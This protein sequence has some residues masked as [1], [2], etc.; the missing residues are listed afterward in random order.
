M[1]LWLCE[2]VARQAVR[3]HKEHLTPLHSMVVAVYQCLSAWL[4][5]Y[6]A[7][8]FDV[9]ALRRVLSTIELG[10][11]GPNRSAQKLNVRSILNI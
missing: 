3:P 10:I 6:P 9:E 11:S 5:S 7:V 2:F 8:L 4:S 1:T